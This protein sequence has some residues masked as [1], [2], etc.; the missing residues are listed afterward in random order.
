VDRRTDWLDWHREYADPSSSLS[1]RRRVVQGYLRRLFSELERFGEPI[2]LLSM[3]AGDGGDVL[4]VLASLRSGRSIQALLVELDPELAGRARAEAYRLDL[5]SAVQVRTAD[6]GRSDSYAEL[7]PAHIVLACGVF[8]NIDSA[9]VRRTVGALPGLLCPSGWV[10]WTRGR[11]A[12]GVDASQF[13]RQLF[14]EHGFTELDFTA[15]DDA[16]F[17]VGL[18]RLDRAPEAGTELPETLFRFSQ[19]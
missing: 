6:A 9:D 5:A 1:R 2:R 15:P 19:A 8:G 14:A 16:K 18:H 3:C 17:R 12:D 7:A 11:G 4:P 13:V 10:V